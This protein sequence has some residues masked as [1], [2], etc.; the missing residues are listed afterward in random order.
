[1]SIALQVALFVASAAVIVLVACLIPLV[2]Q[3][4]R[5]LGELV[6]TT[7]QLKA[8]LD[9]L[10]LDSR[11]LVRNANGLATRANRQLDDVAQVVRTV[12]EW[13]ERADRLVTEVGAVVEPP[14]LLV[15]RNINLVRLGVT[16]FMQ[17]LLRRN[18]HH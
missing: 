17:T 11:E 10:V 18:H 16:R 5:Q 4:R 12:G 7:G 2:F 6:L 8:D 1:M 9:I 14:A 15:A 13:T 3:A